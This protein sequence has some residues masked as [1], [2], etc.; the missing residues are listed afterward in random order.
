MSLINQ[1]KQKIQLTKQDQEAA[2]VPA[3][4]HRSQLHP[5]VVEIEINEYCCLDFKAGVTHNHE[6]WLNDKMKER[7]SISTYNG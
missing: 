7:E 1:R 4:G 6:L 3:W 2:F 5:R